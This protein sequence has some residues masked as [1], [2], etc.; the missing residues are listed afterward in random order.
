MQCS[1][2]IG[3]KTQEEAG[4][5]GRWPSAPPLEM[6]LGADKDITFPTW[7]NAVMQVTGWQPAIIFKIFPL[8]SFVF[9]TFHPSLEYSVCV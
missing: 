7:F 9:Q 2:T 1:F 8:F 4:T 5:G 6:D 3:G